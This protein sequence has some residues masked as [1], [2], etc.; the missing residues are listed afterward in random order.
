MGETFGGAEAA[1]E[2]FLVLAP[3]FGVVI[4]VVVNVIE[5]GGVDGVASTTSISAS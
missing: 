5:G 1:P 2:V 3:R 4:A